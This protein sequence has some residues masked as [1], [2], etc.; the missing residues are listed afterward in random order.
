MTESML[1]FLGTM[2]LVERAILYLAVAQCATAVGVLVVALVL[3]RF[4]RD[5][6]KVA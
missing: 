2:L 5:L 6:N 3:E 1:A 4:R